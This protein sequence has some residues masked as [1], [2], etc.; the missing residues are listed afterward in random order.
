MPHPLYPK[1]RDTIPIAQEVS[2]VL[3]PVW[4][5]PKNFTS[6]SPAE[7]PCTDYALPAIAICKGLKYSAE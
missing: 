6:T 2:W 4:I 7:S 3:G 5:S 1:G